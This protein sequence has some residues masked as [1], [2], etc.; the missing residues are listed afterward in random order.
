M[1]GQTH[2]NTAFISSA[3]GF[4]LPK[5]SPAPALDC[6]FFGKRSS[7]KKVLKRFN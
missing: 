4:F 5:M 6:L 7:K 1:S 3:K 2:L